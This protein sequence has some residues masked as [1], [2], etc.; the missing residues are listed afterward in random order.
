MQLR[1][2]AMEYLKNCQS[3]QSIGVPEMFPTILIPH[4]GS[5]EIKSPTGEVLKIW[6]D[7]NGKFGEVERG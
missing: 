3:I 4:L 5:I 2:N 1:A 7:I 6:V